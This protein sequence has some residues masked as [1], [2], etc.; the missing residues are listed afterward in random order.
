MYEGECFILFVS[1]SEEVIKILESRFCWI[2]CLCLK[3]LQPY[4]KP[5]HLFM[6]HMAQRPEG[7]KNKQ[8][9]ICFYTPTGEKQKGN[10]T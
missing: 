9:L 4:D 1:I 3:Y 2:G 8:G 5:K 7:S 10:Y 6:I